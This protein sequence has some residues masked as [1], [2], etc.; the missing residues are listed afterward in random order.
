LKK[1][2]LARGR[3]TRKVGK[4]S[5][6]LK[7]QQEGGEKIATTKGISRNGRAMKE[8]AITMFTKKFD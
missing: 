6:H 4:D 1:T 3:K 8:V 5:R 2:Q 7:G